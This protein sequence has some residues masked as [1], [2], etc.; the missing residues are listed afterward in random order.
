MNVHASTTGPSAA[1]D[2][3]HLGVDF[4]YKARYGNFIGGKLVEPRSGQYFENV[5][6]IPGEVICE[7]GWVDSGVSCD[8]LTAGSGGG[9]R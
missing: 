8:V 2:S 6:P 7:A 4:P 5:T 9:E 1:L 3:S